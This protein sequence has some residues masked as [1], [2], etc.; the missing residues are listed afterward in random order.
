MMR[1]GWW[2]GGLL[3]LRLELGVFGIGVGK[4]VGL[5]SE[6]LA[7][8]ASGKVVCDTGIPMMLLGT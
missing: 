1:W 5:R 2:G 8:V 3:R 6:D 4:G 7:F